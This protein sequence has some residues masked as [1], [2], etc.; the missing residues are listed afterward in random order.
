MCRDSL[1]TACGG[2]IPRATQCIIDFTSPA[3]VARHDR[4]VGLVERMLALHTKL[5]AEQAPHVK[6]VLQRQAEATDREID[7]LVYELYGPTDA[8]ITV[9]EGQKLIRPID[10]LSPRCYNPCQNHVGGANPV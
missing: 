6:T 9:V 7:R 10:A 1:G 3:D 5:A 4:I 2:V 8:E